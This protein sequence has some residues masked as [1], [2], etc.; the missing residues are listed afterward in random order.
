MIN[1]IDEYHQAYPEEVQVILLQL[2]AEYHF[3]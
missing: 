3:E 1:S 2:M